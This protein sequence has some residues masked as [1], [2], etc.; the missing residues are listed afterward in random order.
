MTH[1]F[2][3]SGHEN[4]VECVTFVKNDVS[5]QNIFFSDYVDLFNKNLISGNSDTLPLESD[6]EEN[7]KHLEDINSKLMEKS[8]LMKKNIAEGQDAKKINKEY[9]ISCG[10]DK[11]IKLW[12]VYANSC[13]Y[14]MLGH[15]NWVRSLAI[16]PNGKYLMSC[17]DDKS[18]RV[19][20]LKSGRCVKKLLDAHDRFVIC[21]AVNQKNPIMASGSIDHLIKI[22]DCK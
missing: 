20:D 17:S 11:M 15:D 19:W 1:Q 14:T 6:E 4:K 16:S 7:K 9:I 2:T 3:F 22:W 10:R 5:R 18:I 21:L 13:V 12:D 8:E